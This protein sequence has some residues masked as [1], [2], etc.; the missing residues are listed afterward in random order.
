MRRISSLQGKKVFQ[1]VYKTGK[2]FQLKE[3][4]IKILES[5]D[6]GIVPFYTGKGQCNNLYP[7]IKI[8]ITLNK[9]YGKAFI[10]NKTKRRIRSICDEL[11]RD[12]A[13]GYLIII[14]PTEHFKNLSYHCSKEI[15]ETLFKR[16]GIL[17]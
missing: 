11:L 1:E 12:V 15:I 13:E 3:V 10:R 17:H 16:A 8:G 5:I 4:Q 2:G 7:E 9:R 6:K 14:R